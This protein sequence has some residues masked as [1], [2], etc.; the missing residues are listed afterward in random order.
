MQKK[1]LIV[2]LADSSTHENM[3]RALHALLYAKQLKTHGLEV[4]LIFDGGGTEWAAK[5][6]THEHFKKLYGELVTDG[7][8]KGVCSFCAAAF[9]V[10][11]ELK[12]LGANFISE[13]GDHPDI[14]GRI[15][16]GETLI[17]I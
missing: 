11:D 6:P 10:E 14:G 9:H 16:N 13:D 5:F 12:A 2:L 8:I 1:Y 3:G 4:E 7:V 15:A 17:T